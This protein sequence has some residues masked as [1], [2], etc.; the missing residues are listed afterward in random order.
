MI[1]EFRLISF[2]II[3]KIFL[4]NQVAFTL[5]DHVKNMEKGNFFDNIHN[6]KAQP[7]YM[8]VITFQYLIIEMPC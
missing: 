5:Y 3:L 8:N 4:E 1:V 6:S 2:I 7:L